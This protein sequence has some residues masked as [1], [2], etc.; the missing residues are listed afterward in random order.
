MMRIHRRATVCLA[1]I[2]TLMPL[3]ACHSWRQQHTADSAPLV[4]YERP[5]RL[6]LRDGSRIAL[7]SA[8]IRGD[9]VH[10]TLQKGTL[11]AGSSFVSLPMRDVQRLDERQFST[12]KTVGVVG[13]SL[14]ALWLAAGLALVA[15]GPGL[16]GY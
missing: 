6:T 11:D 2:V 3:T 5:V 4:Q 15:A 13:A 9:S 14:A 16:I 10:G 7:T 12:G 8:R 1:V